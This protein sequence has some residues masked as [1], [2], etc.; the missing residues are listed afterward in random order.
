[1]TKSKFPS[2]DRNRIL[3]QIADDPRFRHKSQIK[4][5]PPVQPPVR[6]VRSAQRGST[7]SLSRKMRGY[8]VE[9]ADQSIGGKAPKWIVRGQLGSDDFYIAKF[10]ATNGHIEVFTELFNNMLGAALGFNM[11]HHGTAR[12]DEHIY[13]VTRNFRKSEALIHGSLM[14]ADILASKAEELDVI[15]RKKEQEFYSV[16]FIADVIQ[17]YCGESAEN[18]RQEFLNMLMFDA[19]IGSQDRHAK[20]WGVLRP[21]TSQSP[22]TQYRLAPFFDSA[23]A[24]LWDMPEGK[25]LELDLDNVAFQRYIVNSKPCIGPRRESLKASK[26]NHI[27]LAANL[28]E[29]FPHQMDQA[30]A[31][32]ADKDIDGIARSIL[33]RFPFD[34]GFSGLRKRVIL[35]VLNERTLR[36]RAL[37][38]KERENV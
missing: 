3:A 30:Y 20:N 21:E 14:V 29:L 9:I 27:E 19:L 18:V 1:V 13:F 25:L 5:K 22:S 2:P 37:F 17:K 11:A 7:W 4:H 8:V 15:D 38:G 36:L 10:G 34:R 23:R 6:V 35:K 32:I 31:L 28:Q 33:R 24:L 16:D 12:L 26:C